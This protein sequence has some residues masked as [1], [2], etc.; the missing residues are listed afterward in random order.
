MRDFV[1]DSMG[2][3]KRKVM[4]FLDVGRRDGPRDGVQ[5]QVHPQFY[6]AYEEMAQ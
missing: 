2:K 6:R 4:L 1:L 3:F 5:N